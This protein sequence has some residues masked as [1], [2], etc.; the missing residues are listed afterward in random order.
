MVYFSFVGYEMTEVRPRARRRQANL[1]RILDAATA[2]VMA[3]GA[4]ALSIKRVAD[5]A[6]YTAGAL[7]R[8]FPSKNALLTAVVIR[9][10][11]ELECELA[12]LADALPPNEPLAHIFAQVLRYCR[13]SVREGNAYA[14]L[15]RMAAEPRVLIEE[16]ED[17]G[18]ILAATT[19]ALTPLTRAMNEAARATQLRPG[20]ARERT[21]LLYA[22]L[23]GVLQLRKQERLAPAA[24]DTDGMATML[25]R[26]LLSG[27]GAKEEELDAA[28]A[29]ARSADG[30]E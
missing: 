25:V 19:R 5:D 22:S 24:I 13:F 28:L 4:E 17:A 8:Y 10:I 20:D 7:Y 11:G 2:I 14:L 6:D 9:V 21:M 15:S 18:A 27:W 26:T 29:A 23:Q 16:L 3:D 30:D 1:E 12:E